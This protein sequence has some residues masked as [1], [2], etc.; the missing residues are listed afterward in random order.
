MGTEEPMSESGDA[1]LNRF[2]EELR[3]QDELLSVHR[4]ILSKY[5]G[6][7]PLHSMEAELRDILLEVLDD[8]T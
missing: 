3:N 5:E 7:D 4:R 6:D 8:E 1:P 2:L